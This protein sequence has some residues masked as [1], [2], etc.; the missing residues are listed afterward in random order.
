M[1][2]TDTATIQEG[3]IDMT[4]TIKREGLIALLFWMSGLTAGI[5][6]AKAVL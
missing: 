2:G 6:I 1:T 5:A 4:K 3:V